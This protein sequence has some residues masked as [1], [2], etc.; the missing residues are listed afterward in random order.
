MKNTRNIKNDRVDNWLEMSNNQ[1]AVPRSKLLFGSLT[2]KYPVTLDG[3]KTTIFISD[4]NK[5]CETRE[6]YELHVNNRFM[7]YTKKHKS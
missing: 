7:K 2:D 1:V 3:G 6:K 5:E 4:K